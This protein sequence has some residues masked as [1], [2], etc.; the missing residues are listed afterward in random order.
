MED[1][2]QW[3]GTPFGL[4]HPRFSAASRVR[5]REVLHLPPWSKGAHLRDR[6][7]TGSH[8][9]R[10]KDGSQRGNPR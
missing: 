7:Q 3:F 2:R 6:C 9:L 8:S 10:Y 4:V 5:L 1:W